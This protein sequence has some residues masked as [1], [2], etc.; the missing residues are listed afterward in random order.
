MMSRQKLSTYRRLGWRNLLRVALYRGSLRLGC[1]P[2]QK[3]RRTLSGQTYFTPPDHWREWPPTPDDWRDSASYFGWFDHPLSGGIPRWHDDPLSGKTCDHDATPW[4]EIPDFGLAVGDVKTIW[5]MSR[6]DWV[7][8]FAQRA[9]TGSSDDL[10][11]LNRWLADWCRANPAYLGPNWKCGQEASIRVLHLL[12][13]AQILGQLDKPAPD[14]L[15]LLEAHLARIAPTL[16]YALAQDNNHGTSEVAALFLGGTVCSRAG[17]RAGEKWAELGRKGLEERVARLIATDGSFSQYSLNYHRLLLDTLSCVELGRRWL[18]EAPFSVDFL[19]RAAAAVEWLHC[20]VVP[21]SGDAPNL[22][23]NDGANLLPLTGADYRDYRPS[24][25][26]GA[27]LF[28]DATAYVEA[29]S[30][31]Q[32]LAWL[33]VSAPGEVLDLPALA[34]FRG[35]G[36][37][38]LRRGGWSVFFKYP[39]YAFRPRHCDALHLDLWHGDLN[40]CGDSGTYSYSGDPALQEYFQ[41]TAAHNTV[42][43]DD[44]DQMPRLGRFLRG[45]WLVAEGIATAGEEGADPGIE[46]SYRDYRGCR[47]AR[48]VQ[49]AADAVVVTDRVAGFQARAILHWHLSPGNWTLEAGRLV[50][51]A[52]ILT[53]SADVPVVR[54]E[55]ET[56]Q[57]SRYYLHREEI[58]VLEIELGEPG[59]IVSTFRPG[60]I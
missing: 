54:A 37:A 8:R 39:S 48:Q 9:A 13:A 14:L 59:Q 2:V 24:V 34:H 18:D 40:L 5:E 45:E 26:L 44:H 30:H 31:V 41:S 21:G 6:L 3:L 12:V 29:G 32:H 51:P 27:A 35:G 16:D 38:T 36:H 15:N 52:V 55:L 42:A 25:Q 46:V 19:S 10:D 53:W 28:K 56:G 58:P 22:G 11:R 1:H 57:R 43:F 50:G 20:H 23:D 60:E 47:H 4:W 33:G 17:V 49:V 7:L